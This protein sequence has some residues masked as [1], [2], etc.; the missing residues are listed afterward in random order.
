[1]LYVFWFIKCSKTQRKCINNIH[2]SDTWLSKITRE[3]DWTSLLAQGALWR[4]TQAP[5][6]RSPCYLTVTPDVCM[7]MQKCTF[8]NALGTLIPYAE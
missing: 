8:V 3:T 4:P 5:G 7:H 2:F 1:M 6:V